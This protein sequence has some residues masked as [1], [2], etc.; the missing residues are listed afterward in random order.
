[1]TKIS[2]A[3]WYQFDVITPEWAQD[4]S[5]LLGNYLGGMM[6]DDYEDLEG[7]EDEL[8]SEESLETMEEN[9]SVVAEK[10]TENNGEV[11]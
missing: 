9:N 8:D 5:E 2:F 3:A 11:M 4:L 10:T 6:W 7:I 1:M